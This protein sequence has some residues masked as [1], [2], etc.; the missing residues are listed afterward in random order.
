[1]QFWN[2]IQPDLDMASKIN[3]YLEESDMLSVRD[4]YMK[5]KEIL[6]QEGMDK[7]LG[8]NDTQVLE[9]HDVLD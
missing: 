6:S 1:L 5:L 7:A 2:R 4:L 3:D 9:L 8:I